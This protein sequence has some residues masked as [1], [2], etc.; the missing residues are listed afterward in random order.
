MYSNARDRS[1]RVGSRRPRRE[2]MDGVLGGPPR[3]QHKECLHVSARQ[4]LCRLFQALVAAVTGGCQHIAPTRELVL[5]GFQHPGH[6]ANRRCASGVVV[7]HPRS[8]YWPTTRFGTHATS[9]DGSRELF[10]WNQSEFCKLTTVPL[11]TQCSPAGRL[12]RRWAPV[13]PL[14]GQWRG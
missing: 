14:E 4:G 1:C 3:A 13:W 5:R 11:G 9:R 6:G 12:L 2:G 8:L 10:S 7:P